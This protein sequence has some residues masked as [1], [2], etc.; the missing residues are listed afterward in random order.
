MAPIC[1]AGEC[2]SVR[3]QGI[4]RE[5][6]CGSVSSGEGRKSV[7]AVKPGLLAVK[8]SEGIVLRSHQEEAVAAIARGLTPRPGQ[9]A[10]SGLRV[11]VQMATG[12]GKSY[13]GAVAA[14]R[15]A[16]RGVVLVVVP[17][18]NLLT[19]MI[20]SWRAAGRSGDMRAVC[21]LVQ[22]ELPSGVTASTNGLVIGSWLSDAQ[23]G[24]RPL[25][26][27][28]TYSSV[29]SMAEA[30]YYWAK[31]KGEVL[32][33]LDLMVCDEAHRSSGSVQKRWTV[34]HDQAQI[35]AARRL[36]AT[37]TPRIWEPPTRMLKPR[38]GA[39]QPLPE[40]L[41]VSMD[42]V[43]VYGPH[44]FS[45]GLAE[46]VEK[47]LLAPF[48]VVVIE[49]RDPRSERE[50]AKAQPVPWGAGVG[51]AVD[52]S[53][54][55]V[56]AAHLAAMQAGLLKVAAE[57]NLK[58]TITFHNRTIEARYFSET[59]NQTVERLHDQNP[60]K[61]PAEVWAQWLSG[62]HSV[63]FREEVI[64]EFG[65]TEEDDGLSYRVISQCKILGEG[66][67]IP[68]A[69]SIL[70]MGRG[71]MVDIVQAVGRALRIQPGEG[72]M[73]SLIVPVFLKPG[74]KPGDILESDSYNGLVKILTALR[75]HDERMVEALA[76]PQKS[77][78]RTTGRSA[79]AAY[80]P[81]DGHSGGSG[82]GDGSG[83]FTLPVRFESSPGDDVLALFVASRV[84]TSETQLWREAIGHVRNWYKEHGHLNVP[85]SELVGENGN[86]PLGRWLSDR[87]VENA[88][89]ELA[90]WRV[91]Q[92]DGFDMVWS[93]S[94]ARFEAGL[95]WARV[96][97]KDHGGSLAAPARA[98]VGGYAI[99][100]WLA[101][102]R[103][104]AQVPE[105][106]SGA[107][108][109]ERRAELEAVD[110][111]WCPAWPIAWQRAYSVARSWWLESG[112]QVEW[113]ELAEATVFEGESLGRWV[114]AQRAGAPGL[115]AEQR[116]LL[117][118][119]GIEADPELVA[120]KAAADAKPKVSR[121]DRFA[122]GVAALA[123][124][125]ERE[126]REKKVGRGHKEELEVAAVGEGGEEKVERI[127][128]SLG[129]FL[130]NTKA[131]RSKLTPG[132]LAQLAE[133]GV[134]WA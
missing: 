72:K 2:I 95:S 109:P 81:G 33:P 134:E 97:A 37:A 67:D 80:A 127:F 118:A 53:E 129:T 10:P 132:Q 3:C 15:L 119:I 30:Y 131:R 25:T 23:R 58:R 8:A 7:G 103:A 6:L 35:P 36:Y 28:A 117:A 83:A 79:E 66:V 55:E 84:L 22:D 16:P 101:E 126:G 75:S 40:E 125:V 86:Y 88:A 70:I 29:S 12:T 64:G 5:A 39:H 104:A 50:L 92:L 26:L 57:R 1:P 110:P 73:A 77:G 133:H 49:L 41:A 19:Q 42:D 123:A 76:V 59:L 31:T 98:S 107:L 34:V 113:A 52:G 82:V 91:T 51:E 89:G 4:P 32:A 43:R 78:K 44:V 122:L 90:S 61:Y 68:N 27:F 130:N 18:L 124:F 20:G 14:Q 60:A 17:T 111:W 65:L 63:D 96:W 47:S 24:R 121:T 38:E 13:V 128:V 71:S 21:S 9:V 120:A 74:E 115:E 105:G 46:A 85:Y 48:E 112:G 99:G 114:L 100:T 102:L 87:R 69:D 108:A 45:L 56:P 106:E 93:V 116:E 11:T 94:D 54:D 62:E